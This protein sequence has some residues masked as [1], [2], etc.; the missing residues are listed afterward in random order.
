MNFN[1]IENIEINHETKSYETVE[2]WYK[3]EILKKKNKQLIVLHLNIRSLS[4]KTHNELQ[5]YIEKKPIDIIILTETNCNDEEIKLFPLKNYNMIHYCR[6]IRKGGGILIYTKNN[7]KVTEKNNITFKHAENI[8]IEIENKKNIIIQVIYR[9]PKN[10]IKEFLK[11]LRT[12]VKHDQVKNKELI[13]IGDININT[14][15]NNSDTQRY[16]GILS[17]NKILNAIKQPTREEIRSGKL[18]STCIDHINIRAKSDFNTAVIKEKIADHYFI[19]LNMNISKSN[20]EN[21]FVEFKIIDQELMNNLIIAYDWNSLIVKNNNVEDLYNAFVI[22][23]KS[24]YEKAEKKL[25]IKQKYVGNTWI[26]NEIR[27]MI[28]LKNEK[29]KQ[30]KQCPG[31]DNLLKDFKK[32][33]NT[34][35]N[36]INQAKKKENERK[37]S[38]YKGDMKKIWRAIDLVRNKKRKNIETT[39]IKNFGKSAENMTN[40]TNEFNRKFKYDIIEIKNKK[41][42]MNCPT[43]DS[44]VNNRYNRNIELFKI[45]EINDFELYKIVKDL[46]LNKGPGFD[47]IRLKDIKI[48]FIWIKNILKTIIN[49]MIKESYIPKLMKMSIISPIYKRGKKNDCGNYRPIAVLP[50]IEKIFEKYVNNTLTT[51]IEE[52]NLLNENQYGFRK[53]KST[54]TLLNR[55][56]E[57][58]NEALENNKVCLTLSLDLQKAYD[59]IDHRKMMDKLKNIGLD[60]NTEKLF[61]NFFENRKQIVKIGSIYSKE[62]EITC[63]LVQGATISPL[64]YNIYVNDIND[65]NLN[66]KILQY[67]DDTLLYYISDN[68]TEAQSKIQ[69]DFDKIMMWLNVKDIFLNKEKTLSILFKNPTR[70]RNNRNN[71]YTIR[72]HE[73]KCLEN[74]KNTS[75]NCTE[76][77]KEKKMKYLG[78]QFETNLKWKE[79]SHYIKNKLNTVLYQFKHFEKVTPLHIKIML[80]K[81]LCESILR[82]GIE[83]Y[84]YCSEENLKPL[85]TVHKRIIKTTLYPYT[86]RLQRNEMMKKYKILNFKN[87]HKFIM[88]TK[89]YYEEEHRNVQQMSYNLRNTNYRQPRTLNK[90][91][92]TKIAYQL[93]KLLNEMPF[94]LKH[95]DNNNKMKT[96]IKKYLLENNNEL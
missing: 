22:V 73:Y 36:K 32:I 79:Q 85:K 42:N 93:P 50:C 86:S 5:V 9:A 38:E 61:E 6:E 28:K 55:F 84:G 3:E 81:T 90:Y 56:T 7:L 88:I 58:L 18:T 66:T 4:R 67:A 44:M 96:E 62:E 16:I 59:T 21:D 47:K 27:N 20:E 69:D 29:W 37:F 25:K 39:I 23:F 15:K 1:D 43:I 51:Y 26:N 19:S 49:K 83:T 35:N 94:N 53:G 11:E 17:N 78:I 65:L 72:I 70:R 41:I 10:N 92:Q 13:I 48:N 2:E 77:K 68:I 40:L 76:V 60:H 95:M 46:N 87:L 45:K 52:N 71:E 75:C 63:G 33:R 34:L 64:L 12:W 80:Y 14:L 82:Y 30:L 57:E 74:M 54:V 89:H 8:E 31:N 24:L 91:G